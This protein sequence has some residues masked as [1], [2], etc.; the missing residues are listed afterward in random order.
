[1]SQK[2]PARRRTTQT[3]K[4]IA[5]D[6]A[7]PEYATTVKLPRMRKELAEM[8]NCS[9]RAVTSNTIPE[10]FVRLWQQFTPNERMFLWCAACVNYDVRRWNQQDAKAAGMP[11]PRATP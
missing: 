11:S 8:L 7:A 4:S 3:A 1:M 10:G 5:I 6:L 9:P 2:Q